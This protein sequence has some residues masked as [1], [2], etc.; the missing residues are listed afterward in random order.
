MRAKPEGKRGTIGDSE[1]ITTEG[2]K[3]FKPG[4]T[5]GK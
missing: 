5:R 1:V 3:E 4:G 2:I